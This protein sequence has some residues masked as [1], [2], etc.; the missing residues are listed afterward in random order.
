MSKLLVAYE[1]LLQKHPKKTNA[2]MTGTLFG[3][4]DIIA[5]LGF[6][7]KGPD[8]KGAKY[9]YART[10]R[11]VIY[12][13]LIFSFMGD[14]WF[15]FLNNKVNL[16]NTPKTHWTNIA[17]KVG[18]DQMTFAPTV[19]P[20]YFGCLTLME[21]KSLNDAQKKIQ[22]RWW[23]TLRANWAVWPAFQCVNFTFVP[24]QHRLLAVNVVAIFWNTFLSYKNSLST[25]GE[26]KTP[27]YSPP[28]VD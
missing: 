2:I 4:G 16:P 19:I 18:F 23:D 6:S 5:Q 17:F 26:K 24:V 14:K 21:G 15:K 27:V 22:D 3:A 9:D 11:S 25:S 28:I 7:E 20:F 8:G 13:S 12:G 1:G 10:A